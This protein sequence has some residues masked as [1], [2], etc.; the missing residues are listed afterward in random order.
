MLPAGFS[1]F[2]GAK[3]KKHTLLQFWFERKL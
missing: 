1:F 2:F 3:G